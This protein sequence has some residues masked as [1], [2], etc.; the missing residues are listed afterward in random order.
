MNYP[1]FVLLPFLIMSIRQHSCINLL[2]FFQG[3]DLTGPVCQV[4]NVSGICPS[5]SSLCASSQWKFI[6]NLTDGING[7][8]VAAIT[9]CQGNGTLNTSTVA[10]AGGENITVATYSASCCSQKVEL[11][12][13]DRVGNVGTCVGQARASTTVA[14][15]TTL[16][17]NTTSTGGHTLRIS[18]CL[19]ISVVVSLLWK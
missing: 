19:W 18:H 8:G 7:T 15:V 12:I 2:S 13:V 17:V 14:P 3:I 9:I 6:T 1:G 4:V 11:A 5:S 10:G 16:A